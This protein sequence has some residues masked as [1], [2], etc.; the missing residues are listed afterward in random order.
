[1]IKTPVITGRTNRVES[2]FILL[3]LFSINR[4]FSKLRRQDYISLKYFKSI[5]QEIGTIIT[6]TTVRINQGQERRIQRHKKYQIKLIQRFV[7][8]FIQ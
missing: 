3:K 2:K 8:Y 4:G 7:S 6:I 1:M 5:H